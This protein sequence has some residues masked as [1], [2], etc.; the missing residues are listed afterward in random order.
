[1]TSAELLQLAQSLNERDEPYAMV[2]VVRVAPPTSA[3]VGAQAIVTRDGALSG[4][5]GGGCARDVVIAGAREAIA[6]GE[7]KLL[8]IANED[9]VP[10]AGVEQHAMACASN[11]TIELF[12]QPYSTRISLCIMG[13]TPAAD[14]ARFFAQRL[15]IR[16]VSTPGE[17]RVVLIATQG[18]GDAD[19][20]EAA[21]SSSAQHVLMI[22][23]QRKADKLREGMRL[24]AVDEARLA[25][26][27]A[28]AGPDAGAKTPSEIALVA[29]TGVLAALRGRP[30][31][32]AS[33]ES[34]TMVMGAAPPPGSVAGMESAEIFINPVCGIPVS[35]AT[36]K[37]VESFDGEV[38]YFCCDG[39][40]VAFRENPAKYA[41]IRRASLTKVSA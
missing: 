5:I 38:Y 24:R 4:W 26:L 9:D 39:C 2:T 10:E 22:A 16:L 7:P 30:A 18:S 21:L 12:I 23:S 1:M 14:D 19:A 29:M 15:G 20:L 13:D 41:M 27:Q 32:H 25:R 6:S 3:Y 34:A 33:S 8:R 40:W 17:A 35:T 31:T 36:P 37:H 11:G 28:P